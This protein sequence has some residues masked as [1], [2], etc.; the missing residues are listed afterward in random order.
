MGVAGLGYWADGEREWLVEQWRRGAL[1]GAA[2]AA[3][4][5]L[6]PRDASGRFAAKLADAVLADVA[7]RRKPR[8]PRKAAGSRRPAKKPTPTTTVP[9]PLPELTGW[10]PNWWLDVTADTDPDRPVPV[11]DL[12]IGMAW[13]SVT[14]RSGTIHRRNGVSVLVDDAATSDMVPTDKVVREFFAQHREFMATTARAGE[15]QRGYAWVAA[16]NPSDAE[17][18]VRY[19]LPDFRATASAGHGGV[20]FMWGRADPVFGPGGDRYTLRHEFGHHVDHGLRTQPDLSHLGSDTAAWNSAARRDSAGYRLSSVVDYTPYGGLRT[21]GLYPDPT[22]LFPD[23]VTDYGR[24][25]PAEDFAESV[26]L[27]LAEGRI[28]TGR[29]NPGAPRTRIY[30][31]D[32]FPARA[33]ILDQIFP[34]VAAR[35][36]NLPRTPV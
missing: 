28:G 23:G 32:L 35:Q 17:W 1:V 29:L 6:H 12:E 20:T 25:S 4:N 18:A 36:Q 19:N 26:E 3:F 31:R 21:P 30:F 33:A 5:N 16:R 22:R 10:R 11:R 14:V 27:Y 8:A 34:D 13:S 24:S 2:L 7:Q 9:P 15:F